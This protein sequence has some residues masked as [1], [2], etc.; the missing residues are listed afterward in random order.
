[1]SARRLGADFGPSAERADSAPGDFAATFAPNAGRAA[2]LIRAWLAYLRAA[3]SGAAVIIS[4]ITGLRA[5]P[6]ATHAAA[7]AS[8]IHLAATGAAGLAARGIR[9]NAVSPGS[10]LFPRG[11]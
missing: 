6:R 5:A 1:V 8:E 4:S 2:E 9:V 10:I 7:K 11:S 3:R